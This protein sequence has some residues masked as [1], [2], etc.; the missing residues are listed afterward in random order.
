MNILKDAVEFAEQY[1]GLQ[2]ERERVLY[3]LSEIR[4]LDSLLTTCSIQ[5]KP[6]WQGPLSQNGELYHRWRSNVQPLT[7]IFGMVRLRYTTPQSQH[8]DCQQPSQQNNKTAQY[9]STGSTYNR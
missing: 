3:L 7:V 6:K 2:Y 9:Q 5:P 8:V 4:V 1:H